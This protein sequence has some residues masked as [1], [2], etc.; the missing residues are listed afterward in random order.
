MKI[1]E[2]Q[3]ARC[4]LFWKIIQ[5]DRHGLRTNLLGRS[6]RPDPLEVGEALGQVLVELLTAHQGL[7]AQGAKSASGKIKGADQRL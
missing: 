7:G 3:L 1:L 2:L 6:A 5:D 4:M